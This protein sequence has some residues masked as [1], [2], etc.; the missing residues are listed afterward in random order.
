MR[1]IG[2]DPGIS[3]AIALYDTAGRARVEDLP[4]VGIGPSEMLDAAAVYDTILLWKADEVVI[5]YAGSMPKQGVS[6]AFK[7][8]KGYGQLLACIQI[9]GLPFN[10]VQP[11]KWKVFYRL[12]PDK[13]MSRAA[14]LR[15]FPDLHDQLNLKMHHQRAEALLIARYLHDAHASDRGRD[16]PGTPLAT[17]GDRQ[18]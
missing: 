3:G 17:P 9:S 2:I 18:R 12:G 8:G 6:S 5:E 14:A 4:T 11:R 1:T 7:F 16:R 15:L 13:E 10:V